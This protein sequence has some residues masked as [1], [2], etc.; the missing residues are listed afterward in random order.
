[1]HIGLSLCTGNP[2]SSNIPSL[3]TSNNLK[4]Q[5]EVFNLILHQLKVKVNEEHFV[6]KN[7]SWSVLVQDL[8]N[9]SS[10]SRPLL[11]N[12]RQLSGNHGNKSMGSSIKRHRQKMKHLNAFKEKRKYCWISILGSLQSAVNWK[13][14]EFNGRTIFFCSQRK[15]KEKDFLKVFCSF[16]GMALICT[17][18]VLFDKIIDVLRLHEILEG[19][20]FHFNLS[21]CV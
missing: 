2:V 5:S 12:S 4:N 17:W 19:L 15:L 3:Q 11:A 8:V 9:I 6:Y 7:K 1:M 21:V 20:Y 14:S 10:G 13:S 16:N 18:I